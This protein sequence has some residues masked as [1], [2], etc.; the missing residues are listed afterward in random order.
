[1]V[2]ASVPAQPLRLELSPAADSF[3]QVD[4]PTI[5]DGCRRQR[6]WYA[7]ACLYAFLAAGWV[8]HS[9]LYRYIVYGIV[10]VKDRWSAV[11]PYLGSTPGK[12]V[13]MGSHFM[14]GSVITLL[15]FWQV[16]PISRKPH[17]RYWH[18]VGGRIY[19]ICSLITAIGGIGFILQQGRLVGGNEMTVSFSLYGVLV[20]L[21]AVKT[22]TTI[23]R[24]DTA[25]HRRWAL[26]AFSLG[27]ASFLYRM[28]FLLAAGLHLLGGPGD[29][30]GPDDHAAPGALYRTPFMRF[31]EWWFFLPNLFV[32][33]WLIRA[34][35]GKLQSFLLDVFLVVAGGVVI[36]TPC[37]V[38]LAP[39]R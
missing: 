17:F 39:S 19:V 4:P 22:W 9:V 35:A 32:V 6:C 16:F 30:L 38:V 21:C 37:A 26:R 24:K 20:A 3:A 2:S 33:E 25:A 14:A 1:M 36:G 31:D 5:L 7:L 12:A 29:P 11:L 28:Y 15:G 18:R 8:L 10:D 34:R 23:R 27:I 13:C